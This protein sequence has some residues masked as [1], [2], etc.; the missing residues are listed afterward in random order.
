MLT[1]ILLSQR[2]RKNDEGTIMLLTFTTLT[3]CFLYDIIT[4]PTHIQVIEL[5]RELWNLL[6]I[7]TLIIYLSRARQRGA[8]M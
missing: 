8:L 4:S 6:T 3:V 2:E 1:F 5:T 7:T